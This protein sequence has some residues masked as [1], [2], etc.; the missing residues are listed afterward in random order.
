M[1]FFMAE[2]VVQTLVSCRV[3]HAHRWF[4]INSGSLFESNDLLG[5]HGAPYEVRTCSKYNTIRFALDI[6]IER[7]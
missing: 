3:R 1:V 5:A 4:K 2:K 6:S 7:Q